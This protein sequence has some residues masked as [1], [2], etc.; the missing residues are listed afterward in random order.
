MTAAEY[1]PFLA[2]A[3]QGVSLTRLMERVRCLPRKALRS[4]KRS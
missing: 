2:D 1:R 3:G 4:A